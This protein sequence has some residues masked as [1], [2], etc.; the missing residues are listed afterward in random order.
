MAETVEGTH[1]LAH[2]S[3]QDQGC[4]RQKNQATLKPSSGLDTFTGVVHMG[5]EEEL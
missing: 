2:A 1:P 4:S 3:E 5:N